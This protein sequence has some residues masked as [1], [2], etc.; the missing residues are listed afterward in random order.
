MHQGLIDLFERWLYPKPME[1]TILVAFITSLLFL[2][3][4]A[5]FHTGGTHFAYLHLFYIPIIFSGFFFSIRGG[6]LIGLI[7]SMMIGPLMPLNVAENIMQPTHSWAIRSIFFMLIGAFSGIGSA[8][9]R[10]YLKEL[11]EK[12][13]NNPVTLLPN[14]LGLEAIFQSKIKTTQNLSI[15]VLD[16]R[17]FNEIEIAIGPTGMDTLLK[18]IASNLR[19]SLSND[20]TMGHTQAS[21]FS[22]LV[23]D[24]KNIDGVIERCQ[25]ALKSSY[26]VD[27]I[28]IF[29]E[30]FIGVASF[31][32]D[33][34]TFTGLF[35]KARMAINYGVKQARSVGRY[36]HT[37]IDP[38]VE[39]VILLTALNEA[40]INNA[41]HMHYQPKIEL[42]TG[43]ISGFEALARW[44]HPVL[45]EIEPSKF[46][47]LTER[48]MLINPFTKWMLERTFGDM[49]KWQTQGNKLNL[50]VNFSLRNFHDRTI[51]SRVLE[52]IKQYKLDPACI[53]IEVTESAF[54]TNM[55]EVIKTL[56]FLREQG[57]KISIDDFGTGQA[58][59]QYLFQLPVDGLKID[60][61]FIS[62]LGHNSAADAIVKSAVA[63]GH[64]LNLQVV[65]EGIETIEQFNML[66]EMGCDFGQGYL[67][68]PG[69]PY[70][71]LITWINNPNNK[72]AI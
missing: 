30:D 43:K 34:D 14:F 41:L 65:A 60:R 22:L 5:V 2:S 57:L 24:S 32:Q 55:D 1:A 71:Q 52:L 66:K 72:Y 35:R 27:K 59:Q 45:G 21:V 49:A 40:L 28:P 69:L 47:A 44:N 4:F 68:S 61:I 10:A 16:L 58:S 9:F 67:I 51:I 12:Y 63:L 38:S 42:K 31:P 36:D 11:K 23:E 70:D 33:D 3:Y 64:Q 50:A 19:N 53:E 48:T 17:N 54:S 62:E 26:V 37:V 29:V 39:N 56:K 20:I 18:M 8:V 13:L 25:K 46:I 15:I 6:L 7:A